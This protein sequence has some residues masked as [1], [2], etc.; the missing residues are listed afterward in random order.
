MVDSPP[1]HLLSFCVALLGI[2][3]DI[4]G[5]PAIIPGACMRPYI[6]FFKVLILT[7]LAFKP[8]AL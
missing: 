2:N 8:M 7:L 4:F 1:H 3:T 5:C 6:A